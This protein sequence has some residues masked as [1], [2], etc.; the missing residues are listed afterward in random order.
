M[1]TVSRNH[2]GGRPVNL[3]VRE[4][5]VIRAALQL[6]LEGDDSAWES[7]TPSDTDLAENLLDTIPDLSPAEDMLDEDAEED[8]DNDDY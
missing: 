4:L 6:A 7:L 5:R 8:E 2:T 1:G 3:S